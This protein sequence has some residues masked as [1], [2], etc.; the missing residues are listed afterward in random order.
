MQ[1]MHE[2]S[3]QRANLINGVRHRLKSSHLRHRLVLVISKEKS[4]VPSPARR[5]FPA[6]RPIR[7]HEEKSKRVPPSVI[8]VWHALDSAASHI[9]ARA[10]EAGDAVRGLMSPYA[11][12]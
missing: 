11:C 10:L 3:G 7:P 8:S 5:L 12:V 6:G 9:L 2:Y 1:I 4:V